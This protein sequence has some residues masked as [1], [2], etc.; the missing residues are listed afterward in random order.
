MSQ[1][2]VFQLR[3]DTGAN[4]LLYNPVLLNGEMGINTD[5]YQF[6]LGDGTSTWSTLP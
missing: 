6:K 1:H 3:R 5:T 4:W 2:I